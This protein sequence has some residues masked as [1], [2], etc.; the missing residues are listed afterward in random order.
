MTT[1][2]DWHGN[3]TYSGYGNVTIWS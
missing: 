2:G 1:M 3:G